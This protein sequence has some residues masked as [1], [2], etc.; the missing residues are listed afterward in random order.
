EP[1][2]GARVARF[3]VVVYKRGFLAWRS[4]RRFDDLA[5]RHDFAQTGA[6]AQLQRLPSEVSHARHLAFAG[7]GGPLLSRMAWEL[8]L[9]A[10]ESAGPVEGGPAEVAPE[11][12]AEKAGAD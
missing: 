7:A 6:V 11:K 1:P 8:P 9:A 12:P 4:D 10:A 3:T 2:A 5:P